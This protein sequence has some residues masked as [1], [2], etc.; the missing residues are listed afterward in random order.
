M[1]RSLFV[2]P[3]LLLAAACST[4]TA[5]DGASS[6]AAVSVAPAIPADGSYKGSCSNKYGSID[7]ALDVNAG[8][9]TKIEGTLA[10]RDGKYRVGVPVTTWSVPVTAT[11]HQI[12]VFDFD[13]TL[14]TNGSIAYSNETSVMQPDEVT[15][16]QTGT[17]STSL[18]FDSIEIIPHN[19]PSSANHAV[20]SIALHGV[21]T[22]N[23]TAP[24]CDITSGPVDDNGDAYIECAEDEGAVSSS[25]LDE[26]MA[27]LRGVNVPKLP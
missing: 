8:V 22:S 14:Q 25:D 12:T 17:C 7:L 24:T 10:G 4:S 26:L 16:L 9:L 21:K 15:I 2:V 18:T 20:R 1:N 13:A 3:F 6:T 19:D 11:A 23:S 27:V 5:S